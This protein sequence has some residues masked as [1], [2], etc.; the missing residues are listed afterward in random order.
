M[1][2]HAPKIFPSRAAFLRLAVVL[3]LIGAAEAT[4]A[5]DWPQWGGPDPGRNMVSPET[6]LP[7]S[8]QP[9][10]KSPQGSGILPGTTEHVR[11]AVRLGSYIYGNPTVAAGRG[12]RHRGAHFSHQ[13]APSACLP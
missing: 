10:E 1:S 6:G 13:R 12:V 3:M 9:G 7:V 11:W 8:F 5:G 4:Q 2:L